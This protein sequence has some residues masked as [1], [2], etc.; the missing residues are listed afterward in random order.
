MVVKIEETIVGTTT[1]TETARTCTDEL[2]IISSLFM[3]INFLF[4]F[5]KTKDTKIEKKN[6]K[7]ISSG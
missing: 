3:I 6:D 4:S 2:I 7:I 1:T 5:K